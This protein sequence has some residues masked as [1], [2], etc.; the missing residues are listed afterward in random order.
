MNCLSGITL[1]CNPVYKE[2]CTIEENITYWAQQN[3]E[4]LYI[5]SGYELEWY[6]SDN[7]MGFDCVNYEYT[8]G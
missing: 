8:P 5:S 2:Y 1:H 6:C 3:T 4:G 7:N